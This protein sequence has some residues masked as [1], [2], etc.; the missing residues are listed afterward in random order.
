MFS[1]KSFMLAVICLLSIVITL[2]LI[3]I[4]GSK[5]NIGSILIGPILLITMICS[6]VGAWF[7]IKSFKE[8]LN[9][10]KV[11]GIIVNFG[12]TMF[13]TILIFANLID[14]IRLFSRQ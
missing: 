8:P 11:I 12:M 4:F 10:Q 1:K 3:G 14:I 7:S 5:S 6:I 13:I 9:Y 2:S